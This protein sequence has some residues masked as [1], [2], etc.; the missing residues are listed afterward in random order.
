ME[1]APR[2]TPRSPAAI[3]LRELAAVVAGSLLL[4]VVMSWPLIW[5]LGSTIPLDLGDPLPQAWQVAWGGHALGTQP[6]DY[7]Q[8]NQFWPKP[9]TLAYSDALVGYA[10]SALVGSGPTAAVARYDLLFIGAYALCFA[11]TYLLARELGAGPGPAAVAG[12]AFAFAPW[13]MEQNG[14]LHVISS[15]GI[16]LALFFLARGSRARRPALVVAGWAVAAWQLSLGFS[17]GLILAYLLATLAVVAG[18]VW[19]R[20]GRPRPSVRTVAAHAVGGALFALVG[21]VLSRPYLA[22]VD[23]FPDA[24]RTVA[25][26]EAFSGPPWMY[27]TASGENML[28]GGLTGP[29]RDSLKN[30]PE[31]TLFPGL[32]IVALAVAGLG[33]TAWPR[34]LRLGLG[35]G[36]LGTVLLTFGMHTQGG[37]LWPYRV[38]YEVLPGWQGMRTPGRLTTLVSLGLALLAALGA[39][40]LAGAVRERGSGRA[41]G[42]LVAGVLCVAV[43]VEGAG[44][45]VTPPAGPTQPQVPAAPV[46]FSDYAGPQ[47][48]LPALRAEDNRRYLLWSTDGFPD[49]VNGRSS[50]NPESFF[51]LVERSRS[52]PDRDSVRALRAAGVRTVMLHRDRTAGTPWERADRR[53]VRGLGV[54]RTRLDRVT[55]YGLGTGP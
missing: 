28:W 3:G 44:F 48:H 6:F 34:R 26:I 54:R 2:A 49:L 45:S 1:T 42:P 41:A 16:P 46:A 15:G 21:Y 27:L 14:H 11:G 29:L 51:S 20:A 40:R 37:L 38:L 4:S 7:F 32:A 47:L 23:Q 35:L 5:N 17:L 43:L 18:V 55:I 52:F 12:A 50:L 13:R 9:N 31:M 33:A 36:V 8:S 39:A 53:P 25:Q 24:R 10:P 19:M 22:V 30:V